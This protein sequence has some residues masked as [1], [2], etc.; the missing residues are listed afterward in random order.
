MATRHLTREEAEREFWEP[1]K[2]QAQKERAW[3]DWHL[4]EHKEGLPKPKCP[5]PSL[6]GMQKAD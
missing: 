3:N 5:H 2:I 6:A 4:F 1:C